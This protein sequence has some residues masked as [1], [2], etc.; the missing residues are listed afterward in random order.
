MK[1]RN[2]ARI[3]G[4]S[5]VSDGL[6]RK[7]RVYR[8]KQKARAIRANNALICKSAVRGE[9]FKEKADFFA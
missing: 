9:I 6:S 5:Y 8:K 7:E 4:E 2:Y 1:A 3:S